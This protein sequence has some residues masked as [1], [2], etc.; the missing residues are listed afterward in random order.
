[1]KHIRTMT[2]AIAIITAWTGPATAQSGDSE[3][4][5]VDDS[6]A[7]VVTGSKT[8][9]RLRDLPAAVTVL[10]ET[11]LEQ[12]RIESLSDLE[13][14][15]P[16]LMISRLGQVGENYISIRG[17]SSSPTGVKRTAIYID[18]VPYREIDNQALFDVEQVEVLRGPQGVL[19]GANTE[20][21]AIVIRT[22]RP[23]DRLSARIEGGIEAFDGGVVFSTNAALSGPLSESVR[24][25]LSIFASEGA[26]HVSNLGAAIPV[27]ERIRRVSARASLEADLA[28]GF[29]VRIQGSIK[30]VHA[31]G[32]FEEELL[33]MNRELYNALY[34]EAFNGGIVAGEYNTVQ[35]VVK[36]YDETEYVGALNLQYDAGWARLIS[37]SS[38]RLEKDDGLGAEADYTAYPLF[39]SGGRDR[40]EDVYQELRVLSPQGASF[41][42]VGGLSYLR[43]RR[44]LSIAIQNTL[45]GETAP[46][47]GAPQREGGEDYAVFGNVRI[48]L[49]DSKLHVAAGGRFEHST[50][51]LQTESQIFSVPDLGDFEVP[52]IDTTADFDI[53]LPRFAIDYRFADGLMLYANAAR[54]WQPGGFNVD[55]FSAELDA[56]YSGYEPETL[57]TYEIGGKGEALNGDLIWSVAAF[58]TKAK[59]W[60][61]PNLILGEDGLAQSTSV[62]RSTAEVTSKGFEIEAALRPAAGLSL[63][64]GF[65]YTDG[66]YGSYVFSAAQ[67]F[68]D[69]RTTMT[70]RYNGSLAIDY[71]NPAGWFAHSDLA[72]RGMTALNASNS[73]SQS[74]YALLGLSAGYRGERYAVT[75]FGDNLT[76]KYYFAGQAFENP[77]FGDDGVRYAAIGEPRRF[78][79]RVRMDW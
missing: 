15:V 73:A 62:I 74:A 64:G 68:S 59:N 14:H 51:L 36:F 30:D 21:G 50:R 13:Q 72:M 40:N 69:N 41:E 45:E 61:E 48:P 67:D 53:F 17:I 2:A 57:W 46:T 19:Y 79:I 66:R 55:A 29:T 28:P 11:D 23:G 78:G 47:Y 27:D 71:E 1:M 4:E 77:V 24:G 6:S 18:D 49:L 37:V 32:V 7:I 52:G 34:S 25:G 5:T 16:N 9:A 26:S 75:L 54:G 43:T 63:T 42:W 12:A 35:D 56:D 70:P 3:V 10:A 44:T 65:G 60:Q 20:A 58:Y 76:G 38:Y 31:P 8:G 33:P 39:N 22:R